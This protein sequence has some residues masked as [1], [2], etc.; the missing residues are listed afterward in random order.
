MTLTEEG[1]GVVATCACGWL[2]WRVVRADTIAA[3]RE[4]QKAKK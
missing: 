4:H 2:V 1:G 3:S